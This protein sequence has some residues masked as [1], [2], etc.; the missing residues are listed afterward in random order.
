MNAALR[1]T[2]A[3]VCLQGGLNDD[4]GPVQDKGAIAGPG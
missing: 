2:L 3:A 1:A 4:G